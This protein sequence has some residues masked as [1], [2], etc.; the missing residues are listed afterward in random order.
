MFGSRAAT[1]GFLEVVGNVRAYENAF[2]ISHLSI[3]L[4]SFVGIKTTLQ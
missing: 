2:P 4:S 3:A 1:K